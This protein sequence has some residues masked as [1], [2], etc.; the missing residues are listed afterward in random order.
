[1]KK[2][3]ILTFLL[4]ILSGC[5]KKEEENKTEYQ[6]APYLDTRYRGDNGQ[7]C[8]TFYKNGRYSMYDCDS[9]PTD[10]KFDS[11]S[12]CKY[13]YDKENNKIYF[14][15]KNVKDNYIKIKKW[16][17]EHITFIYEGEE[18]TFEVESES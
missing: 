7:A 15:C 17:K 8:L 12:E 4:L 11:E 6:D 3:L 5:E 16:D 10:Y 2:I 1:M 9:E 18:K 14:K 13:N